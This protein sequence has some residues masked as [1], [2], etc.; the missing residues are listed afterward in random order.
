MKTK[1]ELEG[2]SLFDSQ[3]PKIFSVSEFNR[4]VKDELEEQFGEVWIEG[5]VSNFRGASASGHCYFS[6][7]DAEAQLDIVAFRGVMGS[8]KFKLE[9]GLQILVLGRASLYTQRGRFQII[10]NF[11]D[12]KGAGALQLAFL[13]L[14]KKLDARWIFEPSRNKSIPVF[15]P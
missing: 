6:L 12:P 7:K 5:E 1:I 4:L 15:P 9:E 3:R 10:A 2:E 11:I 13:Q 14:K 8:L